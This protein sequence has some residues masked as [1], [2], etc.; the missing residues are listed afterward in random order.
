MKKIYEKPS[1][2][3]LLIKTLNSILVENSGEIEEYEGK[4]ANMWDESDDPLFEANRKNLW[5]E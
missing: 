4:S 2:D 1:T 5:E 3:V